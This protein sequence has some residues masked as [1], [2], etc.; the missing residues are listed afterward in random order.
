[1]RELRVGKKREEIKRR[2]RRRSG[3]SGRKGRRGRGGERISKFVESEIQRKCG[4]VS[5]RKRTLTT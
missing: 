5:R 2:G 1:M 3:R 4:R